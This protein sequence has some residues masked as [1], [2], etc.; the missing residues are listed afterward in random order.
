M[1]EHTG[2]PACYAE[3]CNCYVTELPLEEGNKMENI[4]YLEVDDLL[5]VSDDGS[6]GHGGIVLVD[7]SKWSKQQ[8]KWLESITDSDDPTI[9]DIQAI[10]NNINPYLDE[11][12]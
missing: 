1:A 12:D 9:G 2:C 10:H 3:G 7:T 8:H 5:W 11:R 6:W 4:E